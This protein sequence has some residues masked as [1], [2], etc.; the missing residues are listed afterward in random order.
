MM[1]KG[2]ARDYPDIPF[3]SHFPLKIDEKIDVKIDAEKIM[4]FMKNP[5]EI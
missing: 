2:R 4:K 1:E 3:W 5:C